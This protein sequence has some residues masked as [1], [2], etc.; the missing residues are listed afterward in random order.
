MLILDY[1]FLRVFFFLILYNY[2][3][4]MENYM[5]ICLNGWVIY[6]GGYGILLYVFIMDGLGF[7]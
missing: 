6:L 3:Y 7:E 1:I 5:N 2:Y 4:V